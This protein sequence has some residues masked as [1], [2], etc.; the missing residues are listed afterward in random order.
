MECAG[1]AAAPNRTSVTGDPRSICRKLRRRVLYA[2]R[3]RR[4]PLVTI[5]SLEQMHRQIQSGGGQVALGSPLV[6]QIKYCGLLSMRES[7]RLPHS[8]TSGSAFHDCEQSG[9]HKEPKSFRLR[10]LPAPSHQQWPRWSTMRGRRGLA[11]ALHCLNLQPDPVA[12]I[13][14][15]K[16]VPTG[17]AVTDLI[18]TRATRPRPCP[19]GGFIC[20]C[21]VRVP[22]CHWTRP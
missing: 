12:G 11:R 14:A 13:S 4:F 18:A 16:P 10:L 2:P 8:V 19:L 6:T 20:A 5:L 1:K 9:I 7:R 21:P 17:L 3:R 22:P 15:S